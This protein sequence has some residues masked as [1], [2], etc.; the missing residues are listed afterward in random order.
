LPLTPTSIEF[1]A[2]P[3]LDESHGV[4]SLSR[5]CNDT[6]FGLETHTADALRDHIPSLSLFKKIYHLTTQVYLLRAQ[7]DALHI[8]NTN[9]AQTTGELTDLL[10][11]A[12]P[13]EKGAHALVWPYFVAAAE[14]ESPLERQLFVDRLQYIWETTKYRNVLVG[15]DAL[16]KIWR[17]RGQERWTSGLPKLPTVVM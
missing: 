3:A 7:S 17:R 15:M 16:P 1:F 9:L 4:S 10:I 5:C 8:E 13:T 6:I 14:S 11:A 12:D 2:Q